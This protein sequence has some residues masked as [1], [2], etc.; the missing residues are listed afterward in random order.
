M[1]QNTPER[2]GAA[3]GAAM[4]RLAQTLA[5]VAGAPLDLME[6]L[7]VVASK[8]KRLRSTLLMMSHHA[9]G[10]GRDEVAI[11]VAAALELFQVAALVHDD[12]LDDSDTRRGL[13][14]TH[15]VLEGLH[16]SSGWRGDSAR[17]GTSGAI[18]AGDL[19][20]MACMGEVIAA[21]TGVDGPIAAAVGERFTEMA[22]VCTAGQYLDLRLAA[23]PLEGL[24]DERDAIE[25]VMR[26]KTAS[27]TTVGPLALGAALAGSPAATVDAWAA[28]GLPLGIAFQLRDD[29]LGVIGSEAETGKPSGDDV[30][31]GKRTLLLAH[32]LASSGQAD[33][34]SIVAGVGGDPK[35]VAKAVDALVRS[36]AVDAAESDISRLIAEAKT[37]LD[38]IQMD[39]GHRDRLMSVFGAMAARSS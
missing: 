14:S 39:E 1:Q 2:V 30:R 16:Q 21:L 20:L 4:D 31:E 3:V 38:Q 19:A 15:R 8:G 32:A 7:A 12:V 36:G 6:P 18:L 33:R 13:P 34:E 23:L 29:V 17:F 24:A 26:A 35:A 9:S 10:G 5:P 27:Y 37:L 11:R 28:A 25:A 22:T